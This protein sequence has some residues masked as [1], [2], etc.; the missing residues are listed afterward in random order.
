MAGPPAAAER[1]SPS[2]EQVEQGLSQ[3]PFGLVEG[4]QAAG[5]D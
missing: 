1:V 2:G 3:G 4:R 5:R